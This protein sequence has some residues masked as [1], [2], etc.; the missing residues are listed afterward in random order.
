MKLVKLKNKK[1]KTEKEIKDMLELCLKDLEFVKVEYD[2]YIGTI[3]E[4]RYIP[5]ICDNWTAIEAK[6]NILK[7]ILGE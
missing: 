6:I 7:W 5:D 4:D 3:W 1:M 2:R